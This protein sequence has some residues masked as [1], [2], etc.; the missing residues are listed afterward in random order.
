MHCRPFEGRH[1]VSVIFLKFYMPKELE[2]RMH[3]PV[4]A[5]SFTSKI[6]GTP[7]RVRLLEKL[8]FDRSNKFVFCYYG[9]LNSQRLKS[10]VAS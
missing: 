10:S 3:L 9:Q 8:Q 5:C 2:R 1:L 7:K 6:N 4:A